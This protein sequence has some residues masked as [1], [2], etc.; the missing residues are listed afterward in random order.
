M[1]LSIDI[2]NDYYQQFLKLIETLPVQIIESE[3]E[4]TYLGSE[5][6]QRDR[7]TLHK[8]LEDIESGRVELVSFEFGL[9]E[10][11]SFIENVK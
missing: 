4:P 2:Q 1:H 6:Y 10:L 3:D 11:D 7:A 8:S 5:Q 9:D